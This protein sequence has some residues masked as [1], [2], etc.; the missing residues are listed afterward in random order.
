MNNSFRIFLRKYPFLHFLSRKIYRAIIN[1]PEPFLQAK[2]TETFQNSS[3]IFFIQ[4]GSNDGV[5]GDPIHNLIV[6]NEN[7]SGIFIEPVDFCFK[8]LQKNYKDVYKS[9]SRLIFE[10]S[11]IGLTIGKKKFYYLSEN[12]NQKLRNILPKTYDQLG[13][14]DINHIINH[15]GDQVIPYIIE[16]EVDCL[17]LQ[18]ILDKYKVSKIDLVHIDTEGFDFKVLSQIDF[19]KYRP[20]LILYEHIHLTP[21]EQEKADYLLI[22]Y[23]YHI[24]KTGGDTLAIHNP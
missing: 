23:D 3:N 19:E 18:T 24:Q 6:E 5:T 8:R 22:K 14:F 16:T 21:E 13:S 12:T 2:I 10:N 15:F 9:Q 17:P 20:K 11:A 1:S 4:I 7:F